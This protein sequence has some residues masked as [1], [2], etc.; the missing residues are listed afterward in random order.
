MQTD[1]H[2]TSHLG[3]RLGALV[4]VALAFATHLAPA[5]A[6][7]PV[8]P[9]TYTDVPPA[10]IALFEDALG[11]FADAGLELPPIEVAG[12]RDDDAC[13]GRSG[14]HRFRDGRSR[15]DL[16]TDDAGPAEEFLV[17]HEL[18]HAWD[19]HALTTERRAAFLA[20]R[21]LHEWTNDDLDRWAERGA[22]QAAEIL[23][24]GLID[25]PVRIIRFGGNGCTELRAGYRVLTGTEPLHGHTEACRIDGP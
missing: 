23:V 20:L 6:V 22:E 1:H 11:L 18:A 24:W 15:I 14:V 16:C 3:I 8:V 25:R 21:G 7:Q 5:A 12:H 4:G 10:Q 17:I 9:I 19:R 2:P 13:L